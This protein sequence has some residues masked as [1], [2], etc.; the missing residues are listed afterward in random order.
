MGRCV[1]VWTGRGVPGGIVLAG[2]WHDAV[3]AAER[4]PV[5]KNEARVETVQTMAAAIVLRGDEDSLKAPSWWFLKI[6][7]AS[8][9]QIRVQESDERR[10]FS[11]PAG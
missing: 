5:T 8:S 11:A 7:E 4:R 6:C 2:V 3:M 9:K 1:V 10:K